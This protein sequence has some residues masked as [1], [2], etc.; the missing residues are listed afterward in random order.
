MRSLEGD[1]LYSCVPWG[2]EWTLTVTV[3]LT[4]LVFSEDV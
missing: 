4:I 1:L 2:N 3:S